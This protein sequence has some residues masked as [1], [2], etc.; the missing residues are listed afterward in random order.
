MSLIE[1]NYK[2][3]S[4]MKAVRVTVILPCDDDLGS[5]VK[6]PYKTLYYLNNYSGN[7]SEMTTTMNFRT[8]TML[9]GIAVV[10]IEGDNSFYIDRPSAWRNY[11]EYIKEVVD[12]TRRYFP[13]LSDRREDTYIGGASMGGWGALYNGI[14]Y[15]DIFS[16]IAALSPLTYP[17]REVEDSGVLPVSLTEYFFG[18]REAYEGSAYDLYRILV[19][20]NEEGRLPEL[21]M[22]CAEEDD[23]VGLDTIPFIR[24][25]ESEGIPGTYVINHGNHRVTYWSNMLDEVYEFLGR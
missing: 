3:L 1:I 10:L 4:I 8:K 16:K 12:L 20:A 9:T 13:L 14:R 15:H 19:R 18:P 21:W 5:E 17:Y 25:I 2:S 11:S 24:K 22:C 23:M 7:S 6:A